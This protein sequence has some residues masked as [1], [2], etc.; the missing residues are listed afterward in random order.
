MSTML[1]CSSSSKISTLKKPMQLKS[2]SG[3]KSVEFI[4]FHTIYLLPIRVF[5]LFITF[6]L[7][8]LHSNEKKR[9]KLHLN[10]CIN[11]SRPVL[12]LIWITT[13]SIVVAVFFLSISF[14]GDCVLCFH[15]GW[16]LFF[17]L[18][19]NLLLFTHLNT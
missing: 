17:F 11:A 19:F 18:Q 2:A 8:Q 7:I 3:R 10:W 15:F 9:A 6:T 5:S 1:C 4:A 16:N 12:F 13:A 14:S